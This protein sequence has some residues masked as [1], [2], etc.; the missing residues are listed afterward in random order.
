MFGRQCLP[1]KENLGGGHFSAAH[2]RCLARFEKYDVLGLAFPTG[3]RETL[4]NSEVEIVAN[5]PRRTLEQ[6]V[7][8]QHVQ[9]GFQKVLQTATSVPEPPNNAQASGVGSAGLPCRHRNAGFCLRFR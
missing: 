9:G 7:L 3:L 6:R 1:A 2:D 4:E 8:E 5:P